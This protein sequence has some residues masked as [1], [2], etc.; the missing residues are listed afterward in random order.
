MEEEKL[1]EEGIRAWPALMKDLF[2]LEEIRKLESLLELYGIKEKLELESLE[3]YPFVIENMNR[4]NV[5][6]KQHRPQFQK[7]MKGKS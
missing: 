3:S 7:E 2:S 6:I 4:R 1:K 5:K